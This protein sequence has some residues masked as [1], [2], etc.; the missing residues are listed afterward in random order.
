MG[1]SFGKRLRYARN[2]TGLTQEALAN[3]IGCSRALINHYENDRK[4]PRLKNLKLLAS[5]L[6]LPQDFFTDDEIRIFSV[7]ES[8]LV[9]TAINS[10][11]H[12]AYA[13]AIGEAID[14]GITP[15]ELRELIGFIIRA[16][17]KARGS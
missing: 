8:E 14:A 10:K 6:D 9:S 1:A 2:R 12:T 15:E 17:Q 7:Q 16:K 3:K 5:A 11:D 13:I 4:Q